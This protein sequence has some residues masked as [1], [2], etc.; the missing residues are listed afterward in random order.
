ML[1]NNMAEFRGDM[2]CIDMTLLLLKVSEAVHCV[3]QHE[4]V[5][6]ESIGKLPKSSI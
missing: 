1:P 6:M 2:Y 5:E 3:I 4:M